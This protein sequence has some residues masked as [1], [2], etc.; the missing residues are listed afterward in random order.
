MVQG[1]KTLTQKLGTPDEAEKKGKKKKAASKDGM[2]QTTLN[3]K[4][5]SKGIFIYLL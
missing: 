5:D 2:K 4:K 3:F 1:T